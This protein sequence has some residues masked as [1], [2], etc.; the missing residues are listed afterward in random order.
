MLKT[1]LRTQKKWEAQWRKPIP[2]QILSKSS[3][4]NSSKN[5]DVKDTTGENSEGNEKHVTGKWRE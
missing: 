2:S 4:R 5:M 1:I 3:L